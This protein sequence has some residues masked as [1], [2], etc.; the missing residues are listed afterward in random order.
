MKL[1]PRTF[2]W[3]VSAS[4]T[5]S[6]GGPKSNWFGSGSISSHFTRVSM[7]VSDTISRVICD[8]YSMELTF[9]LRRKC[10]EL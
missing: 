1:C 10:A 3:R 2:A 7:E 4:S 8:V 9:V 6:S 5:I